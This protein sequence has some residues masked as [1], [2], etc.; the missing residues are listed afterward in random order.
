H[1]PRAYEDLNDVRAIAALS[2]GS[3]QTIQGEVVEIEGRSLNDGRSVV[4][5]VLSDDGTNCLEGVWFNQA[6]AA[7]RFRYGQRLSFSGKPKWHR[8]HW[9][10]NSPRVQILDGGGGEEP[11]IVPI[12]PLTEDLRADHLRALLGRSLDLHAA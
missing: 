10:M 4:S 12:Y 2:E 8:D 1:F 11:G 3:I 9:Q 6:F 7:R 5:V